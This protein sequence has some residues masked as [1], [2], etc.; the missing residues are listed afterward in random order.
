MKRRIVGS[1]LLC[2]GLG[3]SVGLA[4]AAKKVE[5]HV[6]DPDALKWGPAPNSLPSGAEVAMIDGDMTKKGSLFTIRI[7]MPDGYKVPPH[8]HPADEHVTVL[9][10]ALYMG[11]GD[12]LDES[13]AMEMRTGAFHAIPK[14]VHHW[15]YSK[16]QTIVQVHG[17]APWGITYVNSADDP[18]K[19]AASK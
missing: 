2:A 1:L 18:R 10:G 6:I 11:L 9:S 14:G 17:V 13:T 12:K 3:L 19:K 15:A 16:G 8:F 7:R 5:T 4:W